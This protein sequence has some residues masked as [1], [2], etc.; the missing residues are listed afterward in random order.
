MSE[1]D[2]L[3]GYL[4]PE[5]CPE[6]MRSI[7]S[8]EDDGAKVQHPL[9]KKITKDKENSFLRLNYNSGLHAFTMALAMLGIT[10]RRK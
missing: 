6:V 1:F 3:P 8:Q 4:P 9:V 2:L 7:A 5:M 10:Q